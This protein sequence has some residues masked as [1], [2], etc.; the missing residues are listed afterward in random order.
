MFDRKVGTSSAATTSMVYV[1]EP[2]VMFNSMAFLELDAA[3]V[4]V[5]VE[6][7]I[8]GVVYDRTVVL[9]GDLGYADWYS[10][11]F[12]ESERSTF[13]IFADIPSYRLATITVT[14]AAGD[15]ESVSCG[16]WLLGSWYEF[17]DAI[18]YGASAGIVDYS[19]KTVD[20]FGNVQITQRAYSKRASWQFLIRNED[21]DR[22]QRVLASMR[23]TPAL[24]VGSDRFDATIIYGWY[25]DFDITIEYYKHSECSI[26][27]E[28]L[29]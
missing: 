18:R 17:A 6:D 9:T 24:Y 8:E 11:F 23:A 10:Y 26:E 3:T 4:R 19:K 5:Q 28:G 25:R 2:G 12:E 14:I 16:V 1:L 20:D 7:D 22:L 21:L 15:G 27:L 13:A 29:I